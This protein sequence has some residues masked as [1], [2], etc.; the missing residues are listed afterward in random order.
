MSNILKLSGGNMYNFKNLHFK[1]ELFGCNLTHFRCVLR[2]LA[3]RWCDQT[4]GYAAASEDTAA[5]NQTFTES[6]ARNA[7]EF[8]T[9][10]QMLSAALKPAQT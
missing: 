6:A 7:A 5:V 4:A 1:C 3:L 10:H 2:H 9:N 8:L